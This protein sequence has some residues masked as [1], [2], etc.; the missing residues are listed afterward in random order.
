MCFA[1]ICVIYSRFKK[2]DMEIKL[3]FFEISHIYKEDRMHDFLDYPVF[4][5]IWQCDFL[6][7][8]AFALLFICCMHGIFELLLFVNQTRSW[9]R[10]ET[11]IMLL[12][13]K[14]SQEP[15][16]IQLTPWVL[17]KFHLICGELALALIMVRDNKLC[18]GALTNIFKHSHGKK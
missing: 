5:K 18:G 2:W 13:F 17:I 12:Y 8:N 4:C 11:K 14:H 1:S 7:L 16:P 3:F 10:V 15:S 6:S 9:L